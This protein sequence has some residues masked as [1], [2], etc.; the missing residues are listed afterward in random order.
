MRKVLYFAIAEM[1]N[2]EETGRGAKYRQLS[3]VRYLSLGVSCLG[4]PTD[5]MKMSELVRVGYQ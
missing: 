5:A 4:L 3:A 2:Q 1:L